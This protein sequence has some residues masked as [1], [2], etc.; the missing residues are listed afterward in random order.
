MP[1]NNPAVT[2]VDAI[3]NDEKKPSNVKP[4]NDEGSLVAS[5]DDDEYNAVLP[6]SMLFPTN[7]HTNI[8]LQ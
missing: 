7:F 4:L 5:A 1:N 2:S 8:A 6:G 3:L